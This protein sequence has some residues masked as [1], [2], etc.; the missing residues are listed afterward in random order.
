MQGIVRH[1]RSMIRRSYPYC[2]TL[3]LLLM[4]DNN[5]VPVVLVAILHILYYNQDAIKSQTG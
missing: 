2:W 5:K 3:T 1:G 4:V